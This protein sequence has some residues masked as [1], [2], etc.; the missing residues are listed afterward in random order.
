MENYV[1]IFRQLMEKLEKLDEMATM[2]NRG[3]AEER[4][5]MVENAQNELNESQNNIR[6]IQKDI[7]TKNKIT[8]N[9]QKLLDE[10]FTTMEKALTID[11]LNVFSEKITKILSDIQRVKFLLSVSSVS[12]TT[13]I[14]GANGSGKST[15]VNSLSGGALQ[16]ITVIPAQKN[17]HFVEDAFDRRNQTISV[18]K[19]AYL[20]ESNLDVKSDTNGTQTERNLL[21]PFTFMITALV[22]DVAQLSTDQRDQPPEKWRKS[23]W[24]QVLNIWERMIPEVSF[25]IDSIH[26]RLLAQRDGQR[27]S[28][29]RLSDGE[30]CI[31][32]YIANVLL[33]NENGY[34]IVDE[35]ETFLNPA[36]YNKLWDIL[37]SARS[38]C[39]FIFTSHNVE[40]ISARLNA[41]IVWC[42]QFTP[43]DIISLR[44]LDTNVSIPKALLTELVGSRKTIVFCE[45]TK[46]SYDYK[47]FSALYLDQFTVIPVGGHDKVIE[48]TK[49]FNNLPA[50]VG[51]SAVGII[52]GDGLVRESNAKQNND[53]IYRLPYN[54]IEM[55]LLDEHVLQCILN[56]SKSNSETSTQIESFKEK[57]IA[58]IAKQKDEIVYNITKNVI[59]AKLRTTFIDSTEG[60]SIQSMEETIARLPEDLDVKA[61]AA[62]ISTE[63]NNAIS[64]GKYDKLLEMCTLKRM[65]TSGLANKMIQPDY[66]N[67][68]IAR[69]QKDSQLQKYL[70]DKIG[71]N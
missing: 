4:L 47:I 60:R 42:K 14:V 32:F 38:D 49:T 45:G 56:L 33:A 13:I 55:L 68:A 46:E 67:F 71:L 63:I 31:L 39:Q 9:Y 61:V 16:N 50:W 11:S 58:L 48:Y 28:I 62:D 21:F 17:L 70:Y 20:R 15:F 69:I 37:I 5:S 12:G 54:E 19:R 10:L 27:Y 44:L 3:N 35:P 22:N 24:D 59:D 52:D 66:T 65:L 23:I 2:D 41:S 43:P 7:Q 34:I 29:N 8:T 51:N 18:Y 36:V 26:G 1:T 30:K 53:T 6:Q 57:A 25:H 40:F 64:K